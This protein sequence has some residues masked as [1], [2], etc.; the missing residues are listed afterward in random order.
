FSRFGKKKMP[1]GIEQLLRIMRLTSLLLLTVCLHLSAATRSQTVSLNVKNQPIGKVFQAIETQTNLMVISND[2]LVNRSTP[3]SIHVNDMSLAQALDMLLK[4]VSLTYKITENTIIVTEQPVSLPM[5][6]M[7]EPTVPLQRVIRGQVTDN[8]GEPLA[9]VTVSVQ[10]TATAT[11]TDEAGQYQI[12][13]P[14][15]GT[16]LVFSL[17]G[18]ERTEVAIG[19]AD[20]TINISMTSTISDLEEV[21]VVAFGTQKKISVTGAIASIQTKEIKQS[22]AANLAVTLAGRLP[23]LT[24]L[25]RSGEPGRDHTALFLRGMGTLN[26]TA[27]II[28]VDGVEREMTYIDPNEV[29]S[30]SILKDAPSTALFGVRGANG[31]ILVTTKRGTTGQPSIGLTYEHGLQGFTRSPSVLSSYEWASLRNQAWANDNPGAD[32]NDPV[33]Q[34]PYSEYALD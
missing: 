22:P 29:E 20:N 14:Q 32:P 10:G 23:G 6:T 11:T 34:P 4:P 2:R 30:V 31:V 15:D 5:E 7:R 28:L 9:G 21:V 1:L 25:Q 18:Y 12:S 13:L 17:V 16:I 27:P 8:E 33:N 24:A 26:A 3:V 19:N